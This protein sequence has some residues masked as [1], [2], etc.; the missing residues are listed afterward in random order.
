MFPVN[1]I[2]K[3]SAYYILPVVIVLLVLNLIVVGVTSSVQIQLGIT[4]VLELLFIWMTRSIVRMEEN[5]DLD[6]SVLADYLRSLGY[7][8]EFRQADFDYDLSSDETGIPCTLK[9]A[10]GNLQLSYNGYRK[11]KVSNRYI[12]LKV[13]DET[14]IMVHDLL[15]ESYRVFSK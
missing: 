10:S 5:D 7:K 12:F 9:L 11:D 1:K 14:Y 13:E 15:W 8:R 3:F 2:I 4:G 6:E